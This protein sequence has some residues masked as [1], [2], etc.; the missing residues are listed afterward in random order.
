MSTKE[1][2][3]FSKFNFLSL[4]INLIVL[5]NLSYLISSKHS[6]KV[7]KDTYE[8]DSLLE[9][10]SDS[11]ALAEISEENIDGYLKSS[12]FFILIHNPWCKWSQKMEKVLTKINLHLKLE[13]QP[14]YIGV[15]D[16]S[17][18]NLEDFPVINQ[19][20]ENDLL[21]YPALLYFKDGVFIERYRLM[22]NYESIHT[23]IKKRI[24]NQVSYNAQTLDMFNYKLKADKNSFLYFLNKDEAKYLE[25]K[26]ESLDDEVETINQV[27]E[28]ESLARFNIF[29]LASQSSKCQ[30]IIFYYT[31]NSELKNK[32]NN[33]NE[34]IFSFFIHGNQTDSYYEKAIKEFNVE[35]IKKFCEKHTAKNFFSYY[36]ERAAQ[37]VFIKKK[38]AIILFRSVFNNKTEYEELKMET[39]SYMKPNLNIIITD[40]DSK[41]SYKL[42]EF[43]HVTDDSLPTL[44]IVDFNG[45]NGNPR[46]FSLSRDVTSE[47][48]LSFVEKWDSNQLFEQTFQRSSDVKVI[49][50]N[51]IALSIN[52]NNFYEKVVL[53]KKNVVV[54]FHA[55]WCTYCKKHYPLFDLV[56]KKVNQIIYTFV[57]IDIGDY[58]DNNIQIKNVPSI[59][60]YP[61]FDKENPIEFNDEINLKNI[62]SFLKKEI[63]KKDDL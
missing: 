11:Y 46:K 28:K 4:L 58:Y 24:Y 45:K 44:R 12:H 19:L 8:D 33:N 54:M 38:P 30:D 7:K 18:S 23:W 29:N 2:S 13:I 48:I 39:L 37:E 34:A 26:E 31:S 55:E 62:V 43:M 27:K 35:N 16:N 47:N 59:R 15:I 42:A 52:M 32:Y 61:S 14:F 40:I 20:S 1:N 49:N 50:S 3:I 22:Q 36:D 9:M 17:I 63:E 56:S 57:Y 53:N 25:T 60:V 41:L 5:M 21:N 10:P 51:S 6:K